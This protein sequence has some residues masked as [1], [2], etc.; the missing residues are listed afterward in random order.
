MA[1][2]S[3]GTTIIDAGAL[4][5][6]VPT[7][8]MILIKTLTASSSATLSFVHGASSVVFD[9]TYDKYVFK[10]INMH[11]ATNEAYFTFN[12]SLDT[13][14]NYNVVKTTTF[15]RANHPEA[16]SNGSLAYR[17]GDDLAQSASFQRLSA[18]IGNGNDEST[19]GYLTIFNPSSTVFQKH[20]MAQ[21]N[22]YQIGNEHTNNSHIAG[23]GNTTSAI[24]AIQFKMHSGNTDS[25]V[26]KLYGI[27]G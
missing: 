1:V 26:I 11:P 25:G 5:S 27:G 20:F 10:F 21:S 16:G 7:G 19:S 15:F 2:V 18:Q 8:K 13:G 6:G 4:G 22:A 12:M 23:Y 24:D 9:D 3:N 17:T 14:S